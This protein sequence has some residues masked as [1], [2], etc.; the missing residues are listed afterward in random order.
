MEYSRYYENDDAPSAA[1]KLHECYASKAD[2][3]IGAYDTGEERGEIFRAREH[4]EKPNYGVRRVQ[5]SNCDFWE[6]EQIM[7]YRPS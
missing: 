4:T 1:S 3:Q 2:Q 7:G 5:M 6:I